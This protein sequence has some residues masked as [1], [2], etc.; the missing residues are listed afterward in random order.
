MS[1]DDRTRLSCRFT[2]HTAA[3]R[4]KGRWIKLPDPLVES[5]WIHWVDPLLALTCILS[6]CS[7]TNAF[8]ISYVLIANNKEN[9]TDLR[10][11]IFHLNF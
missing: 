2:V 7:I 4:L 10:F 1:S 11:N 5:K 3:Y 8:S 6:D 9:Y